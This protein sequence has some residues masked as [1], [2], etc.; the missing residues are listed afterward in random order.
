MTWPFSRS[1]KAPYSDSGS[2]TMMSSSVTKNTL[3]ISRLAAKDLPLPGVPRIRP[4]GFFSSF[5]STMIRLLERALR[6]QYRA[7]F[8]VWNSSCVVKGTK[9]AT[10]EVVRPR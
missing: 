8:P 7:S 4:L 3:L 1:T 5:R 2:Q 10:L 9:I 6:P